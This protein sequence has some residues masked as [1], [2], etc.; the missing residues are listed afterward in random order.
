MELIMTTTLGE[1]WRK[2]FDFVFAFCRKPAFFKDK[3]P[4]FIMDKTI[5][6]FNGP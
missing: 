6:T 3:N 2:Y 4:M 5:P 1:D